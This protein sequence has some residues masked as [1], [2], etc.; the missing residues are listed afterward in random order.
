MCKKRE[1]RQ[2][3]D[4][5]RLVVRLFVEAVMDDSVL[6]AVWQVGERMRREV[7]FPESAMRW[8][9]RDAMH[10]TLRFLGEVE[11]EGLVHVMEA[12]TTLKGS[13][14]LRVRLDRV[15]AFGGRR[16]RVIWVGV[17][18]DERLER[19]RAV[20]TRL[21][22]ALAVAQ[23][24][25][26]SVPYRPHL[27]LGRVRRQ[28]TKPQL[29]SIRSTVDAAPALRIESVVARVALVESTLLKDGPRYR[30]LAMTEL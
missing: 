28:A 29:A 5:G 17:A 10:L 3:P 26:E 11:E 9:K 13:G 18:E 20:R 22:E 1:S 27:T 2:H 24:E 30:R 23:F 4:E 16:P 15:G 12:M 7:S 25:A 6:D 21:D 19:L 8:V 14:R